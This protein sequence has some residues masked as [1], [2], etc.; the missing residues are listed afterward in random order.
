MRKWFN[1]I[2]LAGLLAGLLLTGISCQPEEKT[3]TVA[4]DESVIFYASFRENDQPE[5]NQTNVPVKWEGRTD[6]KKAEGVD[7]KGAMQLGIDGQ[8]IIDSAVVCPDAG[9]VA[10]WFRPVG[11]PMGGSHTYL[12]WKWDNLWDDGARGGNSYMV[13]SQGWWEDSGAAGTTVGIFNNQIFGNGSFK[14][15]EMSG[16]WAHFCLT[17]KRQENGTYEIGFYRNSLGG[18]KFSKEAPPSLKVV[19]PVYLGSDRG[20]CLS[21]GRRADGYYNDVTFYKRALSDEE[22]KNLVESKAPRYVIRD[23]KNPQGWMEDAI[24]KPYKENRDRDGTLLESRVMFAEGNVINYGGKENILQNLDRLKKS[25]YNVYMPLVWHG[26][27]TE[28]ASA[29]FKQSARYDEFI[30]KLPADFN[31]YQF[32]VEEAHKRGLEIHS[33]FAV[34]MGGKEKAAY[35][36][37]FA[38]KDGEWNNGYD[39]KFRDLIVG[40][41]LEHVEKYEVDGISLDFIRLQAGLDTDA[42]AQEYKRMYGRD[43]KQDRRDSERMAEFGS[44]CVEDIIKRVRDGAKKIRPRIV[45]SCAVSAQTKSHG[46]AGNGRNPLRWIN[47]DLMDVA[48]VM[49]YGKRLGIEVLDAAR[50]DSK[51][52]D[53]WIEGLGNYDW[54]GGKCGPRDPELFCKLVDYTRRKYGNGIFTYFWSYLSDEQI[55]ALRKG[56]FK[57]L[58]K[59]HWPKR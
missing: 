48:F 19:S 49:D 23:I 31:S 59:P 28:Y 1:R 42:A 55:E 40:I 11:D 57:E 53:A 17:W 24:D 39:P 10:F 51:N 14:I 54:E 25:G 20:S 2:C 35:P 46:L 21:T 33:A 18:R 16:M 37:F 30:K 8:G 56:P 38:S 45:V 32:M 43:L 6:F 22:I 5:I 47:R 7:G 36:E 58:A 15:A 26:R 34:M 13:I 29:K 3:D 50:K 12:S 27:G 52:P 4:P 41:M 9:T 44:A